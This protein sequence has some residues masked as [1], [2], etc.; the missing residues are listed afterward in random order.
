MNKELAANR[1][2]KEQLDKSASTL[3]FSFFNPRSITNKE[4]FDK[5][6]VKGLHTVIK[7]GH[8]LR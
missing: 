8:P 1:D 6:E 2:L 7:G 4:Q 5:D 3:L